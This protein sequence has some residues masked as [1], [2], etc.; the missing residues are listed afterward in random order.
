[1]GEFVVKNC[2]GPTDRHKIDFLKIYISRFFQAKTCPGT[3]QN[4]PRS[5]PDHPQIISRTPQNRPKNGQK[6]AHVD[7]CSLYEPILGPLK[8]RFDQLDR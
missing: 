2:T 7:L 6:S 4:T 3:P 8:A 1:M 5:S